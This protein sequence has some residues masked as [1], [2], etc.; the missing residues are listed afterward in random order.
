V[1]QACRILVCIKLVPCARYNSPRDT[2]VPHHSILPAT[3]WARS[4]VELQVIPGSC[5]RFDSRRRPR[6]CRKLRVSIAST[7]PAVD[8]RH[9]ENEPSWQLHSIR[10]RSRHL[11]IILFHPAFRSPQTSSGF[12][13]SSLEPLPLC[14][15]SESARIHHGRAF[16]WNIGDRCG[17]GR[18]PNTLY[19]PPVFVLYEVAVSC[20]SPACLPIGSVLTDPHFA[21]HPINQC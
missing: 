14:W 15:T 16:S 18:R 17:E 21:T 4:G 2:V 3:E 12:P 20:S 10:P 13:L 1:H 7:M 9:L 6:R 5:A 11:R 8:S 19:L